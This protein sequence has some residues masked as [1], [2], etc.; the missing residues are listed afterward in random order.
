MPG[1]FETAKGDPRLGAVIVDVDERTGL[2]RKI[3]RMLL[4]EADVAALL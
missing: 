4:T 2:A 3:D 1:R